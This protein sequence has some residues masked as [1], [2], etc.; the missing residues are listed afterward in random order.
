MVQQEISVA[1]LWSDEVLLQKFR[2]SGGKTRSSD[3]KVSILPDRL[4]LSLQLGEM[5][6]LDMNLKKTKT[7]DYSNIKVTIDNG[8]SEPLSGEDLAHKVRM[9]GNLFTWMGGET[10]QCVDIHNRKYQLVL[11]LNS[12]LK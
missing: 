11:C 10:S 8:K 1:P 7:F 3:E 5:E 2:V 12:C 4:G 9:Y 6:K